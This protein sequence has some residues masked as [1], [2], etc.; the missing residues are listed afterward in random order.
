MLNFVKCLFLHLLRG[1]CYFRPL[2]CCV[3]ISVEAEPSLQSTVS[4][5]GSWLV[6]L[7]HTDFLHLWYFV[8]GI[9]ALPGYWSIVSSL[10]VP[11]LAFVWVAPASQVFRSFVWQSVIGRVWGGLE[12]LVKCLVE[13]TVAQSG[14]GLA[15]GEFLG[16]FAHWPHLESS[17]LHDFLLVGSSKFGKFICFL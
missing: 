8:E 17:L 14:P 10:L 6:T 4:V 1:C 12:L 3:C 13:L 9:T 2:F 7:H 15:A 16:V 11:G 5:T